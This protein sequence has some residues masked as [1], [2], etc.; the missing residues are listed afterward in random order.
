MEQGRRFAVATSLLM[1]GLFT[2]ACMQS[3][4]RSEMERAPVSYLEETIP[5]CIPIDGSE[6]DP[7]PTGTPPSV[8]TLSVDAS[9]PYWPHSDHVWNMTDVF[10][11]A[12]LSYP[13]N[14]FPE[15]APHIAIR[16]IAQNDTTRCGIY[17]R[18]PYD[19]QTDA[20][21]FKALR[22]Y[23][24]FVDVAVKEYIIGEGPSR[25]TVKFHNEIFWIFNEEDKAMYT[26]EFIARIY[27]DPKSRTAS[28]YEGKE[29]ILLLR[30]THS[31]TIES[32]APSGLGEWF[33]QKGGDGDI[34]AVSKAYEDALT[35]V[36]RN[37]L[38][39]PLDE[40]VRLIKQAHQN[41]IARTGGR[42]GEDPTL[43]MLVTDANYL[44]D[45]YIAGGAVYEGDEATRLPPPVPGEEEPAQDPT[46]TGEEQPG[47]NTIPAPGEEQTSP[48]PTDDAATTTT[49]PPAGETSTTTS[50]TPPS[51]PSSSTTSP[52]T[53]EPGIE[54]PSPTTGTT[55]PQAEGTIPTTTVTTRPPADE[56]TTTIPSV[57][58]ATPEPGTE[59]P[60]PSTGTTRP[61]AEEAIPLTTGV[62]QPS[63]DEDGTTVSPVDSD[64]PE[65]GTE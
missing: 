22:H 32:W 12:L 36:H 4:D 43:P 63:A 11:G 25:L 34:R 45:Y 5:S 20:T 64:T 24:C 7:C 39:F 23:I 16:G 40:F 38:N 42:I 50:T 1:L 49:Q 35:E 31:I 14:Y 18:K 9:F 46:R 10:L 55:Q 8:S 33:I 47:A 53:P 27:A 62:T 60:Q 56:A 6:L 17:P 26:E 51:A 28:V 58:P 41:K 29:L 61:Q 19:F 15:K 48:S 54:E 21:H 13:G 44:Q 30:P 65:P 57:D 59:E 52:S 3:S 2:Q 37:L